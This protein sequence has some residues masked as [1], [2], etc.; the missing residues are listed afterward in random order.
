MESTNRT[1]VGIQAGFLAGTAVAVLFF[2]LDLAQLRPLA[3]PIHFGV[4]ILGPSSPVMDMPVISQLFSIVIFVGSLLT[5]TVLHFMAFSLL[6]L[7]AVFGCSEC[8][9][10]LNTLTGAIYG[11][12]VGTLVFYLLVSLYG[13][14][15]LADLPSPMAVLFGNL[16]A[17]AVMG[18]FADWAAR[19]SFWE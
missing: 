17:G 15:I 13:N 9:I 6:G 4:H 2:L 16:V 10:K 3:T 11:I 7:G 12:T 19:R 14:S 5:L 1:K 18:G 8:G